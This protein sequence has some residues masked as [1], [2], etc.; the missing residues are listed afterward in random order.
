MDQREIEQLLAEPTVAEPAVADSM[1]AAGT[2]ASLTPFASS[3]GNQAMSRMVAR[4]GAPQSLPKHRALSPEA[5]TL[6]GGLRVARAERRPEANLLA[7]AARVALEQPQHPALMR[8]EA[9]GAAGGHCAC[10]G[11]ILP[12]GDCSKCL[13]RRMQA[14]GSSRN[15]IQRA[16]ADRQSVARQPGGGGDQS[17]FKC[18]DRNLSSMGVAS[19]LIAIAMGTCGL[20][21]AIAGSPTGPGAA[22]T[23]ALAACGC[24]ALLIGVSVG[25]VTGMLTNCM[26]DPSYDR[27]ADA[28]AAAGGDTATADASSGTPASAPAGSPV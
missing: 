22:G 15:E 7:G 20:I 28:G 1:P 11:T 5:A 10:G 18:L 23:A 27:T 19:W 17:V 13:A 2:A 12:G 3:I 4:S 24:V 16:I 9:A 26:N 21:G 14:E 6:L 25:V 8:D